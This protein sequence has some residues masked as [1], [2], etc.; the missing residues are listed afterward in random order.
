M[1][2][3]SR[4]C[5]PESVQQFVQR[6]DCMDGQ[7]AVAFD[8]SLE[9][10]MMMSMHRSVQA[11][12]TCA[13]DNSLQQ[14][15]RANN[16]KCTSAQPLRR[17]CA[18]TRTTTLNLRR[19]GLWLDSPQTHEVIAMLHW[20]V[21]FCLAPDVIEQSDFSCLLKVRVGCSSTG[22]RQW[23]KYAARSRSAKSVKQCKKDKRF[24]TKLE[25][26]RHY[27]TL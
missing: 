22:K 11:Y 10:M 4:I 18:S 20:T 19:H 2:V 26:T 3:C 9:M 25:R 5:A 27:E 21:G 16:R 8:L 23:I 17:D 13:R 6:C 12:D 7:C 14:Q 24:V 1:R 15:G